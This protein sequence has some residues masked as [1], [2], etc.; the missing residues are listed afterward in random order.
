MNICPFCSEEFDSLLELK[1]HLSEYCFEFANTTEVKQSP[2]LGMREKEL[3]YTNGQR[4][5][6]I[7]I[8]NFIRDNSQVYVLAGFS[9]SG[10]TTIIENIANCASSVNKK[11]IILAPTNKAKRVVRTKVPFSC[12]I[13]DI[14]TIH[15]FLYGAPDED[16][17]EWIP[18]VRMSKDHFII[19]D[20]S[21][22][23]EK[24]VY[25]DLLKSSNGA[26]FVFIG[27]P[28]QLKP[29][30]EN[31][32]LFENANYTLKEVKRQGSDSEILKYA[33]VLRDKNSVFY[34]TESRGNV[35]LVNNISLIIDKFVESVINKEDSIFIVGTNKT[36]VQI[37]KRVREEIYKDNIPPQYGDR[38]ISIANSNYHVNSEVFE[39]TPD[40]EL[41]EQSSISYSDSQYGN[42]FNSSEVWLTGYL[43]KKKDQ[44]LFI[45][46]EFQKPSLY[47]QLVSKGQEKTFIES[48]ISKNKNSKKTELSKKV[49]TATYGYCISTYKC[50]G[51]EF[52]K[53]FLKLDYPRDDPHALYTGITRAK[54]ELYL[55]TEEFRKISW[56]DMATIFE[57]YQI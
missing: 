40:Y 51:S 3:G 37:N 8:E 7:D 56:A 14:K 22:M 53:V 44:Y 16:T 31:P 52:D 9:G 39:L 45:V 34:P 15:S 13:V 49:T 20:E 29:I 36:R 10:K 2:I 35:L 33:T 6:L 26:K 24:T 46:P 54:K 57:K 32:N 1:I 41:I 43:Y 50:Q 30:G 48:L 23:I 17:G 12:K 55:S 18:A 19:A 47:H 27:D 42:Y 5:A 4:E 25:E 28:F 21:S 38:L 11:V